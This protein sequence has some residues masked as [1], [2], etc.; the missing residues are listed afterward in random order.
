MNLFI[1]LMVYPLLNLADQLGELHS[2]IL[3]REYGWNME[4]QPWDLSSISRTDLNSWVA[5]V[6]T[7]N[8]DDKDDEPYFHLRVPDYVCA[9]ALTSE[10]QVPL[11]RQFRLPA[12]S[13]TT[14]LP[15]GLVD[16]SNSPLETVLRELDEE[17]GTFSHGSVLSLPPIMVD[18]GRI[19]NLL[20]PFIIYDYIPDFNHIP[21]LG[22]SKFWVNIEELKESALRAEIIHAG[23]IASILM[24]N[25]LGY[26]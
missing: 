6:Q 11:V 1:H 16:T 19:E 18:T 5:L 4:N 9:I 14:E 23:H 12:R 3:E 22:V 17:I 20:H 24:A 21:E 26:I 25:A 2:L 15:G 13:E 8:S 10:G 7:K